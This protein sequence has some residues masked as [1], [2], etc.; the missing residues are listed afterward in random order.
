MVIALLRCW[1]AERLQDIRAS[2]VKE[3]N[4][5]GRAGWDGSQERKSKKIPRQKPP[6]NRNNRKDGNLLNAN[7]K[8]TLDWLKCV[9]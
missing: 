3:A 4:E 8:I 6:L 1:L 7:L 5:A 9:K 2:V